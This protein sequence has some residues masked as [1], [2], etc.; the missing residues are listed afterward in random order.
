MNPD[1]L[2]LHITIDPCNLREYSVNGISAE[3]YIVGILHAEDTV[4]DPL[5]A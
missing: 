5:A 4:R 2:P 1:L 3:T